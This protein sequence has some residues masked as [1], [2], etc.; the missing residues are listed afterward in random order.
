M[1]HVRAEL[2]T[3]AKGLSALHRRLDEPLLMLDRHDQV[4]K[5]IVARSS[6]WAIWL[7]VTAAIVTALASIWLAAAAARSQPSADEI[8]AAVAA[9]VVAARR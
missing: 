7:G 5:R 2:G 9:K 4:L 1:R 8:A 3:T 6:G